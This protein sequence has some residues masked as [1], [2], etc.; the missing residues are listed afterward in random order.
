MVKKTR[1]LSVGE[2]RDTR[3]LGSVDN[4]LGLLLLFRTTSELR[5]SQISRELGIGMATAHRLLATLEHRGFVLQDEASRAYMVGPS[6]VDL[7]TSLDIAESLERYHDR[8]C[9]YMHPYLEELRDS[10]NETVHLV[11]VADTM[12]TWL[13]AAE[14]THLVKTNSRAGYTEP[15]YPTAAGKAWLAALTDHEIDELYPATGPELLKLTRNTVTSR[16]DLKAELR[17][18]RKRGYATNFA[19]SHQSVGAIGVVVKDRSDKPRAGIAISGPLER[20]NPDDRAIIKKCSSAA[21][22]VAEEAGAGVP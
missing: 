22:Q 14:C 2:P 5:V 4:A 12:A 10:V 1:H 17:R 9:T 6:L 15:A 19:E 16:A 20:I 7:A 21:I 3:T 13:D 11:V 18:V 8:L